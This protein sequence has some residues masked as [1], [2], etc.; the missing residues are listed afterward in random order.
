MR[1][2]RGSCKWLGKCKKERE[3]E[4]SIRVPAGERGS[5]HDF[6]RWI[7][8]NS[9]NFTLRTSPQS[10]QAS[11]LTAHSNAVGYSSCRWVR[12]EEKSHFITPRDWED[13]SRALSWEW[14]FIKNLRYP[15]NQIGSEL[16]A[17]SLVVNVY[18]TKSFVQA[19]GKK[20]H[21]W[22]HELSIM[23]ATMSTCPSGYV[24]LDNSATIYWTNQLLYNWITD[25]LHAWGYTF[26]KT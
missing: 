24:R 2:V 23:F 22:S 25:S 12:S 16:E 14:I 7:G 20:T 11:N 5:R 26:G 10:S 17:S 6:K 3:T 19:A 4:I 8:G 18:N 13:D 15:R 9:D 21:Q 1:E